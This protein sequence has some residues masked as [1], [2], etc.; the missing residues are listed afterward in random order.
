MEEFRQWTVLLRDTDLTM[1]YWAPWDCDYPIGSLHGGRSFP[2][3]Q[4]IHE[5]QHKA[6]TSFYAKIL[7]VAH[8]SVEILRH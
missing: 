2:K 7:E 3:F 1:Q 5:T 6:V 4:K 8:S